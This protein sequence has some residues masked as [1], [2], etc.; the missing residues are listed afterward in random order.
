[1]FRKLLSNKIVWLARESVDTLFHSDRVALA[2][3]LVIVPQDLSKCSRDL[4]KDVSQ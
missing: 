4:R 1:M 2:A 3:A